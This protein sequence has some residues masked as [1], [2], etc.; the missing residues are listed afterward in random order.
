MIMARKIQLQLPMMNWIRLRLT[1]TTKAICQDS[2][3]AMANIVGNIVAKNAM[4]PVTMPRA[5]PLPTRLP[6][7]EISVCRRAA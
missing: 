7:A 6:V 1:N 2:N 4:T 3:W 5:P